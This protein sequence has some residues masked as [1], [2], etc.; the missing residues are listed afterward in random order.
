MPTI[1]EII[2][3]FGTYTPGTDGAAASF[4]FEYLT[5]L[6]FAA[7]VIFL[8]HALVSHSG[9]LR[10][11]A[12]PAPVVVD[13]QGTIITRNLRGAALMKKLGELMN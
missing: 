6:G 13:Q 7:I 1:S 3:Y 5:S 2:A 9:L 8:G 11:F 10:K 12:I 4:Q